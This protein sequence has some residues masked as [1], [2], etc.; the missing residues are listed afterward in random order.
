M[1]AAIG[2]LCLVSS[3]EERQVYPV[4]IHSHRVVL[5]RVIEK[6][7]K[8]ASSPCQTCASSYEIYSGLGVRWPL[9]SIA[10]LPSLCQWPL[11]RAWPRAPAQRPPPVIRSFTA[12]CTRVYFYNEPPLCT[13][14]R[15]DLSHPLLLLHPPFC[16]LMACVFPT[17]PARCGPI[18]I[19]TFPPV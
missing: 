5:P 14:T 7:L 15:A 16:A 1:A 19:C 2:G 13:E 9:A 6:L 4:F 17:P 18:S 11:W 10:S 12:T 3:F 8:S